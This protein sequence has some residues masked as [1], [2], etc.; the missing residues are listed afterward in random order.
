MK[1]KDEVKKT[2]GK[3]VRSS[4]SAKTTRTQPVNAKVPTKKPKKPVE[5]PAKAEITFQLQ[6]PQAEQVCIVGSF[7]EWDPVANAL[8]YDEDGRWECIL[9]L[10]PGEYQYRFI[11][12][13]EWYD[14]PE[15][16][17][18]RPNGFGTEN[19]VLVI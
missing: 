13:G 15:N 16:M 5:A 8:G 10:D 6:A 14:D 3:A 19:C 1:K 12:D 4:K 11:V 17:L 18:R 9:A 7:N 2:A